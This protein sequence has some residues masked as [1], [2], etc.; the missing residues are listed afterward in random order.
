M[1]SKVWYMNARS[2][3]PQTGLVAKML[4][5]FDAAGFEQLIK[6]G[7]I[8]AI[9]IH[10]GEYNNTAY[11]RPVYPR[12]IA[13]KVK[14]LGGRPFVCDT[15]TLTYSPHASRATELDL[16]MTAERNGFTSA[17][18]G[19]PFIVADGFIGTSDYR[20]DLPEGYILKEAYVAQAIA[21][22]DVLITLTHFKGHPPGRDWRRHQESRDRSPVETRQ[23]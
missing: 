13:D 21:A 10:C 1:A 22:A 20:V 3:S 19:C 5:V 18:L 15:T 8:V 4:T 6:P 9:K 7:D 2:E 12:A 16:L 11:L 14:E 17:A 23:A